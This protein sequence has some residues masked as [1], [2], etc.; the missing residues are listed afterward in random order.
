M[1]GQRFLARLN[2]DLERVNAGLVV[3]LAL[4]VAIW[5]VL[6]GLLEGYVL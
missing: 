1:V 4:C 5:M 2:G 3:A 6:V